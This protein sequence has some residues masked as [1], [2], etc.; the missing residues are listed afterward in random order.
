MSERKEQ[1]AQL[2][3]RI[4]QLEGRLAAEQLRA[5]KSWD[6]Y[7]SAMYELVEVKI[8]LGAVEKALRGEA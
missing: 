2:K 1:P 5:E 7:R 8:K 6:A 3:R 4:Q